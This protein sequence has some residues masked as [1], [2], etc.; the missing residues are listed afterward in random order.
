MSLEIPKSF[1]P[2]FDAVCESDGLSFSY[3]GSDVPSVF[4]Y[5]FQFF[6]NTLTTYVYQFFIFK[7]YYE[8]IPELQKKFLLNLK[9]QNFPEN[10]YI[11]QDPQKYHQIIRWAQK[12]PSCGDI[13]NKG[14]GW[15]FKMFLKNVE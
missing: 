4:W 6:H 15:N 3:F 10:P 14:S 2:Y 1:P 11:V 13:L 7:N 9:E 8:K 5:H 12:I